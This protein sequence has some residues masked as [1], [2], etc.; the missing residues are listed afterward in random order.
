MSMNFS[1]RAFHIMI[2]SLAVIL[3]ASCGGN[4]S[5]SQLTSLT[6]NPSKPIVITADASIDGNKKIKGPWFQ[7]G[8]AMTNNTTEKITIVALELEVF[9]QGASGI[10][11]SRTVAFTPGEFNFTAGEDIECKF[12]TFG[13]WDPGETKALDVSNSLAACV[14]SARFAVGGNSSGPGGSN[15]RYR[16]KAKPL[17]WFGTEDAA[18]DRYDRSVSFFTQ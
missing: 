13:T 3:L 4:K 11:E 6:V 15:F 2:S 12:T 18:T 16:V 9:S 5:K 14:R 10:T 7:F 1:H 17:G 8:M